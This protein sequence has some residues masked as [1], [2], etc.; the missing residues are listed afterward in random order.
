MTNP[1]SSR[2]FESPWGLGVGA[3]SAVPLGGEWEGTPHGEDDSDD[4]KH[5]GGV[6]SQASSIIQRHA[7][8]GSVGVV[9]TGRASGVVEGVTSSH[10]STAKGDS[11]AE[12]GGGVKARSSRDAIV[13]ALTTAMGKWDGTGHPFVTGYKGS[14]AMNRGHMQPGAWIETPW[15]GAK[16]GNPIKLAKATK[17][18]LALVAERDPFAGVR[19]ERCAVVGSGGSLLQKAR[20]AR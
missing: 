15:M 20:G 1:T 17:E 3:H 6:W 13:T 7:E 19:H 10:A 4:S 12:E 9:G 18:R 11:A 2:V 14:V 16:T 5:W 8:T